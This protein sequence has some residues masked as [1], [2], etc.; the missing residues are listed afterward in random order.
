GQP[1][2]DPKTKDAKK[3][4]CK[5]AFLAGA[6]GFEPGPIAPK[7]IVLPLDHAPTD[8]KRRRTAG[9]RQQY[10]TFPFPPLSNGD[11]AVAAPVCTGANWARGRPGRGCRR[12]L[13]GRGTQ[14]G[15]ERILRFR[16]HTTCDWLPPR[17]GTGPDEPRRR[18]ATGGA[19]GVA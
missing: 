1:A 18:N 17:P 15:R 10:H 13:A 8:R 4:A 12:P 3:A 2:G 7:A 6:P 16:C 11:R 9:S 19:E 14:P 5:A